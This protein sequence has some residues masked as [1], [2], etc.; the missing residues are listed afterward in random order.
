MAECF[1]FTPE[2]RVIVDLAVEDQNS[3]AIVADHGLIAVF[4]IDDLEPDRPQ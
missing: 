3:I 4:Q 1:Q 2:F